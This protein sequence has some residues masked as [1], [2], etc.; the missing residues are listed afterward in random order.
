MEFINKIKDGRYMSVNKSLKFSQHTVYYINNGG[1]PVRHPEI[2]C[3][4]D[5]VPESL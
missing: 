5:I 3:Q 4:S 1:T 2:G